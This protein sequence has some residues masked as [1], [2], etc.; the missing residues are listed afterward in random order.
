MR[1]SVLIQTHL[2]YLFLYRRTAV[3]IALATL[4]ISTV[5]ANTVTAEDPS[6]AEI[7]ERLQQLENEQKEMRELLKAKDARLNE[8]EQELQRVK[9]AASAGAAPAAKAVPAGGSRAV[10]PSIDDGRSARGSRAGCPDRTRGGANA[11]AGGGT[12]STGGTALI[13]GVL[14][15][16]RAWPRVYPGADGVG[17]GRVQRL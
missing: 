11:A 12:C 17:R 5:F 15:P 14:R 16:V 2:R 8:V 10:R 7:L 3:I 1:P 6:Q 13:Q 4:L 9:E